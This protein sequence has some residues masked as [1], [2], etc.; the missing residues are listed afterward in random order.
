[1]EGHIAVTD[2]LDWVLMYAT[3][4]TANVMGYFII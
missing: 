2:I 1:M 4:E 3:E